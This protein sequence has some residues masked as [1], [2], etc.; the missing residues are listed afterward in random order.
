MFFRLLP[1]VLEEL[2]AHSPSPE[3]KRCVDALLFEAGRQDSEQQ[4]LEHLLADALDADKNYA[5]QNGARR[6]MV[7]QEVRKP[8]FHQA[9]WRALV[10]GLELRAK[11]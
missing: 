11:A 2:E 4:D 6:R 5:V 10:G 1:R 9:A 8:G 3:V 7:M